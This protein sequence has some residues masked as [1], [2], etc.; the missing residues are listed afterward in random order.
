VEGTV[1]SPVLLVVDCRCFKKLRD[2]TSRFLQ[3]ADGA[4]VAPTVRFSET[5][6][7]END[8][9]V[10]RYEEHLEQQRLGSLQVELRKKN[11]K[12]QGNNA[13]KTHV[14]HFPTLCIVHV[15]RLCNRLGNSILSQMVGI[16]CQ[17]ETKRRKQPGGV[18]CFLPFVSVW[19]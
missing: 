2:C 3:Y 12:N 8:M 14:S 17:T 1:V 19:Q 9:H 13:V 11:A 7:T 6:E 4:A 18:G 10:T 5:E 16:Y 15:V